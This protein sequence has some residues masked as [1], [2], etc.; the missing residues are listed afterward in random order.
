M[1]KNVGGRWRNMRRIGKPSLVIWAITLAITA[2]GGSAEPGGTEASPDDLT[3]VAE[4]DTTIDQSTTTAPDDGEGE[5][6]EERDIDGPVEPADLAQS[7]FNDSTNVDHMW[8][9]LVPGTQLVFE[10][11]TLEDDEQIAHRVVFTVTDLTKEIGGVSAVVIWDEDYEEGELVETEI[12][13]F[14]QDDD[15]S[16][17][18]LGE[19]PEEYEEG[20]FVKAPAWIHGTEGSK[21]GILM[22]ANPQPDTPSFPQGWAPSVEW[23]DRGRVF[24]V[25]SETCVAVDCY[26]N[27][28][29]VDEFSLSEPTF[30]QV[31]YYAPGVGNVQV[32]Y[33]GN[34]PNGETLELVELKMLSAEELAV[35]REAALGL[36]ANAYERSEVYATTEPIEVPG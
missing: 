27:V 34:D 5:G 3:T 31:K 29:I 23:D 32:G 21:A 35:A 9:P 16:V 30:F 26:E 4:P 11:F 19:Y 7:T 24:E 8:F 22:P 18:L 6:S 1:Q 13:F 10:G 17:W 36:E 20:E 25:G 33:K 28:L 2:C 14:A 12:A 15:G